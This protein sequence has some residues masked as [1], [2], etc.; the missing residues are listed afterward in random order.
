MKIMAGSA[1]IPFIV[2]VIL[3]IISLVMSI[4]IAIKIRPVSPV[5]S[6]VSWGN[7]AVGIIILVFALL[8]IFL[9]SGCI[10]GATITPT[11]LSP[12]ITY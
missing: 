11:N 4:I 2:I 1:K 3:A 8:G 10:I 7:V 6:N 5:Y 9:W 12:V